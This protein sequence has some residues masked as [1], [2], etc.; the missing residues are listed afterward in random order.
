MSKCLVVYNDYS[1]LLLKLKLT[2]MQDRTQ[3]LVNR[4]EVERL[5]RRVAKDW[6]TVSSDGKRAT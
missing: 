5:F 1:L 4:Y 2:P 3:I 6:G